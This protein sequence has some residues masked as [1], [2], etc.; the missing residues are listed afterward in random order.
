MVVDTHDCSFLSRLPFDRDTAG[1][2]ARGERSAA[3]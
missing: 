2:R 1:E 3:G